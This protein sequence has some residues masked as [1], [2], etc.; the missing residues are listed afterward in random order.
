MGFN[1]TARITLECNEEVPG[2][3]VL[4]AI[5]YTRKSARSDADTSP[6]IDDHWMTTAMLVDDSTNTRR[7]MWRR[8]LYNGETN[9]VYRYI[10]T[11]NRKYHGKEEPFPRY[12][13]RITVRLID[14]KCIIWGSFFKFWG[15]KNH[16][17]TQNSIRVPYRGTGSN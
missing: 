5:G 8:T 13:S 10:L 11:R 3:R 4:P 1:A 15:G 16:P 12:Q 9:C 7:R 6:I 17:L 14:R 2:A